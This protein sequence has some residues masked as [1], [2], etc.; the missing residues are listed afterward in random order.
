MTKNAFGAAL[1]VFSALFAETLRAQ[2]RALP[3]PEALVALLRAGSYAELD[4]QVGAYQAAY[5]A[6]TDREWELVAAIA[7]FERVDPEL[8]ARFSAWVQAKPKSYAAVL[9]RGVYWYQ[10]AWSSRGGRYA[11]QTAN[12]RLKAM[13]RYFELADLD[14][15]AS[16]ALSP[17]PQLSHRYLIGS[18]MS[19]GDRKQIQ[20]SF[21]ASLRADPENY[22]SRRAFLNALRPQWGGSINAMEQ[23]IAHTASAQQ[24]PKLRA[25]VQRLKASVLGYHALQAERAKNYPAALDSY[26][27]GLAEAEDSILLAN[28]GRVLLQLE[29]LDEAFRDLDRAVALEPSSGEA[30][31]RRGNLYERRKKFKEAVQDYARAG[32]Y[33]RPYAM[34]RLGLWYLNGGDGVAV[35]DAQAVKW[36]RLGA[37]LGDDRAQMGLGYMYSAGRGVEQDPRQAVRLWR[38]SAAQ[39]NQQAQKYLDDVPWWWRAR[40]AVEDLFSR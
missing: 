18:A 22:A 34:Q 26:A 33:G 15:R 9:A 35:N 29:R 32:S 8:E 39:G 28:R 19:R 2:E 11:A 10:R 5:E 31:E 6:N 13:E 4:A 1:L 14:L 37:E 38:L 23:V 36:L 21:E 12:L 17:R 40:F 7:G 16:L 3:D 30:L 20:G 25:V 27:K 24:T